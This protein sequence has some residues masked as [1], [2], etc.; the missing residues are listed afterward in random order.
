MGTDLASPRG[1]VTHA[2]IA[3]YARRAA[4][5]GLVIV[6]HSYI[7]ENGKL[8]S[9]QLG[10]HDDSLINGLADLAEAIREKGTPA[11]IQINHAGR[12]ASS[13]ICGSQ[14]V[15]P[16]TIAANESSEV[17]RELRKDEIKHLISRF[18]EAAQRAYEAGFD[19]LEIH[20]A[21]GFLLNEF[22]SPL[23][24][25]RAD[26]YGGSLE[27]RIRFPLEVVREIRKRLGSDFP[28]LYRLGAYDGPD[29]GISISECQTFARELVKA[30]INIID[31][32]GGLIGSRPE[33]MSGQG[34]F[35]PLA[36]K[37]KL[38]VPV[39][40]IGVGG[41]KDP[42]FADEAI[43]Q[44][45]I[46]LAAVGRAILSDPDWAIKAAKAMVSDTS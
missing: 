22:T 16:S 44:G 21:H 5:V 40:V 38:V 10:I 13:L 35:L 7:T 19:A 18:G 42:R 14:P 24:N 12:R 37:I 29:G 3:H 9:R 17:P 43:R 28:L 11:A 33:H 32:S 2:L 39:P 23:S 46:D 30:G 45:K 20:G 26:E 34:Y 8:S 25:K 4:G 36:Q 27:N 6:E 1:E 41:I 15:A 31:V